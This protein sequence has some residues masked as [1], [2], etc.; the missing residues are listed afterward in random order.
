VRLAALFE[1]IVGTDTGVRFVAY[2][3]S[4]A[5]PPDADVT[6]EVKSPAA[7]A[8]LAQAPG[9]LGLARGYV[10]GHIDVHGD[11]YTLLDRM[12][13]LTLNDLPLS[14]KLGALR[15][16]GIKPLLMRVEPPP[17]EVRRSRLARLGLRHAKRR[18]AEAIHHHYDVSNRFYEWVLGPS[19]AYTCAVFPR[20]DASLEEAQYTKFDLVAKKLDLKP[21]MRLLDVGCGWGGM[22]MHAAQHHGVR[23][24]GVTLSRQQAELAEKRAAEAGLSRD[25][26][27]RVQDYRDVGDG[28]FDAISSIGMFEHVGEARLGEYFTNLRRLVA[29]GGRLLNH[30]ISRPPGQRAR[31]PHRSFVNRYVFP[32]GELHEVGRVVSAI[33]A[34][35]F[36]A[37]HAE[38]LR[39]HYALT[40]RHWVDNLELNWAEAVAEV[41]ERRARVWRLY[42]AGSAINF[43]AGRTHIHQVLGTPSTDAGASGMPLRPVFE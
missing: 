27:I 20:P 8:Y 22:V 10:S 35:G 33:Q 26:E 25:V 1:Q 42:M 29:P 32:D 11:L 18:D 5:G 41:G 24:V 2:D 16:V 9:E 40:L 36:E 3:G 39:E 13:S 23:A 31:L 7:L 38:N 6:I 15:S 12:W 4:E 43:E 37:R 14:K 30:G 17:Q 19:M 28:P 21:G 34:A